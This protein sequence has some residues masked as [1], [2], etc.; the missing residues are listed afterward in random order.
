MLKHSEIFT[1]P[2]FITEHITNPMAVFKWEPQEKK[3]KRNTTHT[4]CTD[5]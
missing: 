5:W 4:F 1:L 2:G 3:K